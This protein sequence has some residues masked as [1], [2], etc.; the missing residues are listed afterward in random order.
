MRNI[1]YTDKTYLV[2]NPWLGEKGENIMDV[3]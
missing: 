2:L 3:W 1:K